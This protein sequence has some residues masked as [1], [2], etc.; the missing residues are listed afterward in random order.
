MLA[1]GR[2][3]QPQTRA[4]YLAGVGHPHSRTDLV[5]HRDHLSNQQQV[6]WKCGSLNLK[7]TNCS[8]YTALCTCQCCR[9]EVRVGYVVASHRRVGVFQLLTNDLLARES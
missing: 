2:L 7:Y 5:P 9:Y 4:W 1:Y 6:C 3:C 8:D